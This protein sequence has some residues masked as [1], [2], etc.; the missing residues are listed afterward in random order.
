MVS[1]AGLAALGQHC[2]WLREMKLSRA[3][4]VTDTG[5]A[6]FVR[7]CPHLLRL[8]LHDVACG[9]ATFTALAMHCPRLKY[10]RVRERCRVSNEGIAAL[11]VHCAKLRELTFLHVALSIE[12]VRILAAGCLNLRKITLLNCLARGD[13]Q[14]MERCEKM[15]HTDVSVLAN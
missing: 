12:S 5:I 1:N 3:G 9:D 11:A 8:H 13:F 2:R 6:A 4:Q 14:K 10:L 15:F 7:A